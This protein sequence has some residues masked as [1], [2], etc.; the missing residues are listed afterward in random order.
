MLADQFVKQKNLVLLWAW[1]VPQCKGSMLLQNGRKSTGRHST[2]TMNT[3]EFKPFP[4][5]ARLRRECI[6]TEKIDGT[7][8]SIYIGPTD[9]KTPNQ[10]VAT[11]FKKDGTA[12][13]MWAGSRTRWI[14]TANDNFDFAK[15]VFENSNELFKLGE[16]HHFG[17]WWGSGIQ[18]GYGFKNG[19]RFFSLFNA[20]RWVEHDKPTASISS[21]NPKAP[22]LFQEHAPA[23][24][25]VVPV[26]WEELFTTFDAEFELDHLRVNGSVAAKGFMNPEGIV[27]YHKAAGVGFKMTIKDDDK[28]KGQL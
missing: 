13:G 20:T 22:P 11:L 8:A 1:P 9:L 19:E 3:L 14:T 12:L 7:N 23:C 21:D 25:K 16:G 18:R 10:S 26:L 5:M 4:K 2:K 15:W 27:V 17:E 24:C 6:I 28:P